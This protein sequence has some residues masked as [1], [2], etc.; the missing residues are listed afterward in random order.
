MV[1]G[2]KTGSSTG[3]EV[4]RGPAGGW[5]PLP[6]A[7]ARSSSVLQPP[8]LFTSRREAIEPG[9]GNA[10]AINGTGLGVKAHYD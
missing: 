1:K 8:F 10:R 7:P 4:P 9:R 6:A 5:A 2:L 3:H